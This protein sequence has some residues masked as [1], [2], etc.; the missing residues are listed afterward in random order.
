MGNHSLNSNAKPSAGNASLALLQEY[1]QNGVIKTAF[2]WDYSR[3]LLILHSETGNEKEGDVFFH[4]QT[5]KVR[6]QQQIRPSRVSLS[7]CLLVRVHVP[8]RINP[9]DDDDL[10]SFKFLDFSEMSQQT[11]K[12]TSSSG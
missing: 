4:M 5:R 9:P 6:H 2:P 12:V 10:C 7:V 8:Q 3:S 1:Q 11:I